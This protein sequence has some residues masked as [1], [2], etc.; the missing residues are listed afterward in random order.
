MTN[1]MATGW[2]RPLALAHARRKF[3]DVHKKTKSSLSRGTLERIGALYKTE[4]RIRRL[5]PEQ[6]LSA[7]AEHTAPRMAALHGWL[8]ATLTRISGRS[9][10]A[11]AIRYSL[12]RWEALTLI[13]RD[14]RACI[15]N[16][17]AERAMRPIAL[18]R[19]NWTFAG[20]D[21]GGDRAA[22]IYSLIETAKLHGLDPEAYLRDV[23]ARITHHPVNR[24]DELLPWNLVGIQA[25][26]DQCLAA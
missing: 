21:A 11:R 7:R 20:S 26:L 5:D 2:S 18:G 17:A 16:S 19:C 12:S 8:E 13:L 25:R 9:D 3:C 10:L 14:G 4:D 24:L 22:A 23:I 6:R 15:D 1:V